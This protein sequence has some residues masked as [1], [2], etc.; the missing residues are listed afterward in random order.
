VSDPQ[1]PGRP[2]TPGAVPRGSFDALYE[3]TPPWEIGRPQP[4]FVELAGAGA[5]EGHVLDVGC[6]T[7]EHALM[8]AGLGLEA[9]G[10]DSAPT[11]IAI[12][13]R[14]AAE[15]GLSVRFLVWDALDLGPLNE[16]FD[17]VID[18]GLFHVF[19][20][21]D[22]A[23][24][25]DSLRAVVEPGGRY[26]LLCF[27]DAQAGEFGPRRVSQDEIRE[28]FAQGWRVESV[29]AVTMDVTFARA[30]EGVR[31]WRASIVRR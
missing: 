26:H 21:A 9:I 14:K 10:V 27:S 8:A 11:A 2:R 12:A 17:T 15:R 24:F 23:A 13:Q 19:D 25:V 4:A 5:I 29:D 16:R 20:D 3:G 1:P 6:G 30:P 18:S 7:G 22:R 28:S 31:A